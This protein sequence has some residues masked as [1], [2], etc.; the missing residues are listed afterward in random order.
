MFIF[1]RKIPDKVQEIYISTCFGPKR[2]M[3][4]WDS[5]GR[6]ITQTRS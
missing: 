5:M 4:D 6:V 3:A 2:T 1:T